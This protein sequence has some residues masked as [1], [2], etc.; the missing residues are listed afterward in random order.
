MSVADQERYRAAFRIM[1]VGDRSSNLEL[2][3]DTPPPAREAL[4]SLVAKGCDEQFL[5]A[6]AMLVSAPKDFWRV[7]GSLEIIEIKKMMRFAKEFSAILKKLGPERLDYPS[8]YAKLLKSI[9]YILTEYAYRAMVH[10]RTEKTIVGIHALLKFTVLVLGDHLREKTGQ[11]HW[12][13]MADVVSAF[14]QQAVDP[15]SVARKYTR[16]NKDL[17]PV[18][19][20]DRQTLEKAYEEAKKEF[21]GV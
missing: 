19:R 21:P 5:I 11:F 6:C 4:R 16:A 14:R 8:L 12:K 3:A 15:E 10:C 1:L 17:P 13:K 20:I 7:P 9:P 2:P 18:S